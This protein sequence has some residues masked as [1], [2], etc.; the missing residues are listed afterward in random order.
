[1]NGP[2][3]DQPPSNDYTPAAIARQLKEMSIT[4]PYQILAG[5]LTPEE[6]AKQLDMLIVLLPLVWT[7]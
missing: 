7:R 4:G 3:T 1:M 2:Q 6:Y 5:L